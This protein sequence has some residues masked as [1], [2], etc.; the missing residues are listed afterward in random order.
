MQTEQEQQNQLY[1]ALGEIKATQELILEGLRS[2]FR[3]DKEAFGK[4]D[5]RLSA[6]E[7][8]INIAAGLVLAITT[9]LSLFGTSLLR[10]LG[11][12]T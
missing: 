9:V 2:H 8:K 11:W 12:I 3:D 4:I 5:D 10:R 1:T 7:R 6:V